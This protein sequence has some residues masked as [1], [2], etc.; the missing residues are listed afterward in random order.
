MKRLETGTDTKT[1]EL[2]YDLTDP[3]DPPLPPAGWIRIVLDI[4]PRVTNGEIMDIFFQECARLLN[5]RGLDGTEREP[6]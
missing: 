2:E 5:E 6:Q 4:D 3:H 1:I